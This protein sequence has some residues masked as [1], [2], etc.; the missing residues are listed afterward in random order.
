MRLGSW[1]FLSMPRPHQ[2]FCVPI[3]D[4]WQSATERIMAG[5]LPSSTSQR[6]RLASIGDAAEYQPSG[7]TVACPDLQSIGSPITRFWIEPQRLGDKNHDAEIVL[8]P[9]TTPLDSPREFVVRGT[10]SSPR[11]SRILWAVFWGASIPHEATPNL[12]SARL[13]E[14]L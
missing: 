8:D 3:H 2:R 9:T 13:S 6:A 5:R 11:K 14:S 10:V 4:F 7:S 1:S 12:R